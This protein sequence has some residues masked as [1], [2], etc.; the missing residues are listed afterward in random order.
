METCTGAE[1][2]PVIDMAAL[3][4]TIVDECDWGH[5]VAQVADACKNW[6]IFQ[7]INHGVSQEV[8]EATRAQGSA[9]FALPLEVRESTKRPRGR[10]SGYG[11]GKIVAEAF[12]T[13]ISVEAITFGYPHSDADAIATKLWPQRSPEYF[14]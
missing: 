5:I 6:G 7:V 4:R 2:I 8:I 13:A 9:V 11:N 14:G 1:S 12:N 3:R 10:L